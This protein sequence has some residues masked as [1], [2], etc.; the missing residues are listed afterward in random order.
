[1]EDVVDVWRYAILSCMPEMTTS[2]SLTWSGSE[3]MGQY[4]KAE[5]SRSCSSNIISAKQF[6]GESMYVTYVVVMCCSW[7]V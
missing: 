3:K 6:T 5:I 2:F 4:N 7:S 1:M